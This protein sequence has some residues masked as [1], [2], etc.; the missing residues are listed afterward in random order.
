M[1]DSIVVCT[2]WVYGVPNPGMTSWQ[3]SMVFDPSV[4]H[5]MQVIEGNFL[6]QGGNNSTLFVLPQGDPQIN[7]RYPRREVSED[8]QG[9]LFGCAILSG[10]TPPVGS[11][12]LAAVRFK[13]RNLGTTK[14]SA[15]TMYSIMVQVP[16]SEWYEWGTQNRGKFSPILF[17]VYNP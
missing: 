9:V 13:V 14:I 7:I 5:Y 4:L 1:L 6:S 12:W 2:L 16:T 10:N 8:N 17:S 3:I 11:G 15:D